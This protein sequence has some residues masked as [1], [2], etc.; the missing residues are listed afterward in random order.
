MERDELV[1][2]YGVA[3][4]EVVAAARVLILRERKKES[5]MKELAGTA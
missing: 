2:V 1:V 3:E 5:S 4:A